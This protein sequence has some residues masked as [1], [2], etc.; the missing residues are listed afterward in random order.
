MRLNLP[1]A[2]RQLRLPTSLPRAAVILGL[3]CA[4]LISLLGLSHGFPPWRTAWLPPSNAKYAICFT[5]RA[6]VDPIA[7]AERIAG[8]HPYVGA[9]AGTDQYAQ[10]WQC[11]PIPT[12]NA[13]G[14]TALHDA[15]RIW[16]QVRGDRGVTGSYIRPVGPGDMFGH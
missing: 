2:V 16:E 9:I 5:V 3:G 10:N 15:E 6:G 8:P 14:L 7:V 1:R 4:F 11:T 13:D 12:S